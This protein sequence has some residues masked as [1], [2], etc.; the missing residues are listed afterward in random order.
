MK[1]LFPYLARWRSANWT[2]YHQLLG[3]LARQGHDIIVFEPPPRP[4][5]ETNYTELP[6]PLPPRLQVRETPIP[7]AIPYAAAGLPV[8]AAE[9]VSFNTDQAWNTAT[10]M[11][12]P[13]A[14]TDRH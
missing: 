12:L 2:R 6:V 10:S 3:E 9:A 13:G 8:S 11:A 7:A 14:A 5:H 4:S 1:L